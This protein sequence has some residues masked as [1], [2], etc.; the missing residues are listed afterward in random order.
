[1][2]LMNVC[3]KIECF[4]VTEEV[5]K[6]NGDS[7]GDSNIKVGYCYSKQPKCDLYKDQRSCDYIENG[8]FYY[9]L[10]I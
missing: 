6:T 7:G 4:Y 3:Y 1:M 10:Y 8:L 2:I 9:Y 5:P